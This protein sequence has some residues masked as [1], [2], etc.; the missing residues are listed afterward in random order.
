MINVFLVAP[1]SRYYPDSG[2][3]IMRSK[4]EKP[5]PEGRLFLSFTFLE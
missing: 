5:S 2:F 4:Q 3:T 1:P